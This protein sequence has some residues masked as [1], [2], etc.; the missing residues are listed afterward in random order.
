MWKQEF[1]QANVYAKLSQANCL[2]ALVKCFLQTFQQTHLTQQSW[3]FLFFFT[4]MWACS[5]ENFKV[6]F[7][8]D[9]MVSLGPTGRRDW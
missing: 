7:P 9:K 8:D 3:G 4:K 5:F 2:L 6:P 1:K